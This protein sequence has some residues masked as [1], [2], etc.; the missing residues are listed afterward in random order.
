M[1]DVMAHRFRRFAS[2]T[3]FLSTLCASAFC[4]A[5]TAPAKMPAVPTTKILAIGHLN[6]PMTP[7]MRKSIMPKEVPATVQLYLDGKIDQWYVREDGKGV[8]FLLNVTSV[9]EARK[10][11]EALPLGQAHLME[12]DL[13]PLGPLSPLRLLMPPDEPAK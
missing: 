1:E 3:L 9:E 6:S 5:Q 11:L 7:E 4:T 13:M 8:V 12:F 10:L 2:L